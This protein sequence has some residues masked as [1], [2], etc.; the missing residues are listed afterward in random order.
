MFPLVI[1]IDNSSFCNL[2]CSMCDHKNIS[3]HRKKQI[4]SMQLYTK[5]IDEIAA[6][7]P[8]TR[9]WEIFFGDPF[10]CPDMPERVMYAK[11]SGLTDVVLNTNGLAMFTTNAKKL[12]DAGLDVLYVGIDAIRE[13]T[14]NR[15]RVGGN[16]Q[17]VTKNVLNYKRL[18]EKIGTKNQKLFVQLVEVDQS[19]DE[20]QEFKNF[21]SNEGVAVKIRPKVSWG[22]LITADNLNKEM[23][24]VPC[25]WLMES[26]SVC[27]DGRVALCAVD[28][29]CSTICGDCNE[30][31]IEEIWNSKLKKF[32]EMQQCDQY[33][34]LPP[35]CKD[36]LD[37][38]SANCKY[39]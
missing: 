9:V 4:M 19:A 32:R 14:Y 11:Q 16:L 15:I 20:I 22:G 8:N 33:H 30:N 29:H 6:K 12:I 31:T 13:E 39:V 34:L 1:L 5:L 26:F 28:L 21:W 17:R 3:K 23:P 25:K 38:Q 7:R 37:W 10:C 24:R 35:F 18:L 2:R 36:C 27:A